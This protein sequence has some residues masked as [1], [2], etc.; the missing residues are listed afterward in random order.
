MANPESDPGRTKITIEAPAGARIEISF[1]AVSEELLTKEKRKVTPKEDRSMNPV[2]LRALAG[3]AAVSLKDTFP[4]LV[5][6]PA[7]DEPRSEILMDVDD[8]GRVLYE[9]DF[10]V[11]EVSGVILALDSL[12][13]LKANKQMEIQ[14]RRVILEAVNKVFPEK[15]KIDVDEYFGG[16][17]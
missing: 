7:G 5:V 17:S 1:W 4:S 2:A 11:G 3:Y 14:F 10:T 9:E 12:S 16:R 6:F 15:G 8:A 13:N